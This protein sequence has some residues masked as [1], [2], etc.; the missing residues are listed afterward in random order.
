MIQQKIGHPSTSL[1]INNRTQLN[2]PSHKNQSPL[3]T[4]SL[5]YKSN[6]HRNS[7][8]SPKKYTIINKEHDT[9]IRTSGK[10]KCRNQTYTKITKKSVKVQ[11]SECKNIN[12]I[13]SPHTNPYITKTKKIIFISKSIEWK[14]NYLQVRKKT[15]ISY[16]TIYRYSQKTTTTII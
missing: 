11:S 13:F 14:N 6:Q 12:T 2:N 8:S 9:T 7:V 3:S 15:D 1:K 10:F 5:P 4:N 16:I